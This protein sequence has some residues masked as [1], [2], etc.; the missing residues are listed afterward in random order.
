MSIVKQIV[1]L[2]GGTI[3]VRSDIGRGTEI[4]L[5]LP[6]ESCSS[7]VTGVS[8]SLQDSNSALEDPVTA[9][10]RRSRGRV[11]TIRGFENLPGSSDLQCDSLSSLKV[12]IEKY[13]TDWFDLRISSDNTAA[14]ILI[15]DESAFL[16]SSATQL[17]FRTLLIL[18]SN[19]ARRD[20]YTAQLDTS[21]SIE[22]VS[23]P[24]GPHRLAKAL[25]NC[26]DNEDAMGVP[27]ERR[28]SQKGSR[29][30]TSISHGPRID[31]A[32]KTADA[33]KS[34]RLI[35][36]LQSQIIG[37]S[38]TTD[39]PR[40]DSAGDSS[41]GAPLKRK[42]SVLKKGSKPLKFNQKQDNVPSDS[43]TTSNETSELSSTSTTPNSSMSNLEEESPP[44]P[45]NAPLRVPKMLLVEVCLRT[46]SIRHLLC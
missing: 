22:F 12:S 16:H 43:A 11:V 45:K 39:L 14:D 42:P 23:K 19:S 44:V 41:T 28:V 46:W 37:F 40:S 27:H 20:I 17:K 5:S 2:A 34:L 29:H 10:R 25:L 21:Q 18:C 3:D 1:D 31:V 30:N 32:M 26:F 7:D 9:V 4:T 8:E 24:C 35:G 33:G 6:L 13:I 15:C 36:N 38:P